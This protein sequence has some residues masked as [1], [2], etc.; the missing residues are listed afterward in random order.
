[1]EEMNKREYN[2]ADFACIA[3]LG[4]IATIV[5]LL[6]HLRGNNS[7]HTGMNP[8]AALL[9][10]APSL[11]FGIANMTVNRNSWRNLWTGIIPTLSGGFGTAFLIYL[12]KANVLLQYETWIRRGMP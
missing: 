7:G 9:V 12:D 4:S 6:A 3:G 1:M 2:I 10:F 11:A 5:V 8:Y